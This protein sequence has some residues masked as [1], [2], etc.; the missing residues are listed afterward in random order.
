MCIICFIVV[1]VIMFFVPIPRKVSLERDITHYCTGDLCAN[2]SI[3]IRTTK[4]CKCV[5]PLCVESARKSAKDSSVR[6]KN[7]E[8][9]KSIS[10][11][12]R[13]NYETILLKLYKKHGLD[14]YSFSLFT[15]Y[16]GYFDKIVCSC[17][18]CNHVFFPTISDLLSGKGCAPCGSKRVGKNNLKSYLS[19]NEDIFNKIPSHVQLTSLPLP[20]GRRLEHIDLTMKCELH[21]VFTKTARVVL[22]GDKHVCTSCGLQASADSKIKYTYEEARAL[23]TEFHGGFYTYPAVCESF[24]LG[25][26]VPIIC[27]THGEFLQ[28]FQNHLQLGHGCQS[29]NENVYT[30]SAYIQQSLAYDGFSNLYILLLQ[31]NS[32]SFYKIGISVD[33]KERVRQIY[34][35][36]EVS[37]SISILGLF[38]AEAGIIWDLE[39]NLHRQYK[40]HGY[41][42]EI[43]F[44]GYTECFSNIDGILDHIP[45]DQLEVITNLLSQQEIAT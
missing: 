13:Y 2:G 34:Y 35:N 23:A 42:P 15:E 41:I 18:I 45:F 30:R 44:G 24:K 31:N 1:E 26:K 40:L 5:C 9:R 25:T 20:P 6:L 7:G 38:K 43:K 27:P 11:P 39:T 19:L 8:R 12:L 22:G 37:Y 33:V 4:K 10:K 3:S 17:N 16:T 21:G 14:R 29:C 32:E 28:S 36:S